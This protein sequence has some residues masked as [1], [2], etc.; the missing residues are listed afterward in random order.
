MRGSGGGL[1]RRMYAR[2][3][4]QAEPRLVPLC[5]AAAD[6]WSRFALH[7]DEPSARACVAAE[8]ALWSRALELCE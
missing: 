5:G 1:F 7:L 8:D 2:F 3:L 6:A 4:Q